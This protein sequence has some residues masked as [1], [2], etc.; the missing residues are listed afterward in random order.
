MWAR[1]VDRGAPRSR[2]ASRE[3]IHV[4]MDFGGGMATLVAA[5]QDVV[6]ARKKLGVSPLT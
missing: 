3:L 2:P 6:E 1:V 4:L 5:G